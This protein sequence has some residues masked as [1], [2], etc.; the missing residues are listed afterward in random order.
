MKLNTILDVLFGR[1]KI[2]QYSSAVDLWPALVEE[3]FCADTALS[4]DTILNAAKNSRFNELRSNKAF[5]E[6][7]HAGWIQIL[8]ARHDTFVQLIRKHYNAP[9][10]SSVVF[11]LPEAAKK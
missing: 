11:I 1:E 3:A 2:Q 4:R 10:V 8:A 5:I 9:A 7:Q 6:V